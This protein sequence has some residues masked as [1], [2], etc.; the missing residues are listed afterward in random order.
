MPASTTPVLPTDPGAR[1]AWSYY[2]GKEAA[3][4]QYFSR[5]MGGEGSKS[6]IVKRTE[7]QKGQGD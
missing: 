6:V 1:K 7:L 2:V 3:N 4:K 5:M